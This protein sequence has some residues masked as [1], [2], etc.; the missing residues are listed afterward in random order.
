MLSCLSHLEMLIPGPLYV[1]YCVN[2]CVP[3]LRLKK[4]VVRLEGYCLCL[5][6]WDNSCIPILL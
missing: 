4:V 5:C 3:L 1:Y 2:G 6:D